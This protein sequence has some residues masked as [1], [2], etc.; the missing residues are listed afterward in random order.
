MMTIFFT[1]YTEH[2]QMQSPSCVCCK[3]MP[4]I[5]AADLSVL[6]LDDKDITATGFPS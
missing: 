3:F 1:I 5:M 2:V 4:D 6:H